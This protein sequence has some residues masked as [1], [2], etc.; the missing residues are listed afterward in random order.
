MSYHSANWTRGLFFPYFP[1]N[2]EYYENNGLVLFM[3]KMFM[4]G[5]VEG[6]KEGFSEKLLLPLAPLI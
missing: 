2:L 5:M 4:R 3:V 1:D 6:R